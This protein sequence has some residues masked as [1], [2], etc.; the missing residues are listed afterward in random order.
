[1]VVETFPNNAQTER[2][3]GV[4]GAC[5]GVACRIISKIKAPHFAT[6]FIFK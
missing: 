2:L 6:T 4:C 1:M 5:G 3:K